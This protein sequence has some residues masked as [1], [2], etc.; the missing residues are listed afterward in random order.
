MV[1]LEAQ[2]LEAFFMPREFALVIETGGQQH[3]VAVRGSPFTIG[4]SQDCDAVIPD[5]RIS[6]VHARLMTENGESFV[7]D[8]GSRHGTFVNGQRCQRARLKPK[9]EI[10]LGIPGLKLLFMEGEPVVHATRILN[11]IVGE[12]DASELEKLRLFLE[13]ARSLGSGLVIAEVLR[14]MLDYTLRLTQ[15]ERGFIYL[16]RPGGGTALS[17]GLDRKGNELRS[18]YLLSAGCVRGS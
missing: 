9:D 16:K 7:E 13:A 15:A 14:N 10:T 18:T 4:R 8:A 11:R 5:F 2:E 1:K 12:S 6:R 3:K 17:C